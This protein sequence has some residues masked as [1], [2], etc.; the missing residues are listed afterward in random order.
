MS[1]SLLTTLSTR[2]EGSDRL[3]TRRLTASC[4]GRAAS[5]EIAVVAAEILVRG[6]ILVG[7]GIAAVGLF[8]LR[9]SWLVP[10]SPLLL[11]VVCPLVMMFMMRGMTGGGSGSSQVAD[12]QPDS[13]KPDTAADEQ[14]LSQ[15]T[16][17]SRP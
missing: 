14:T 9:P 12:S 4:R 10:A 3:R 16:G 7:I 11:L 17:N 1:K 6:E 13:G 2:S 8:I 15:H 5:D